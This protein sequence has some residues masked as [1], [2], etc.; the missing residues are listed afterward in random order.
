MANIRTEE[1]NGY[2]IRFIEHKG[3][4][5]AVLK[6]IC[7]ALKLKTFDVSRRLDASMKTTLR[8]DA[9]GMVSN[10]VRSRARK[11]QDMLVVN[12]EGLYECVFKSRVASAERF[13]RWTYKT[14]KK[15]RT[16]VGLKGYEAMRMLDEDTQDMIDHMLDSLYYD[17]E[18]GLLMESVTVAGGD[19]E[20]VPFE[21]QSLVE[22]L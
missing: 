8:I 13:R 20:Q 15:L 7:D 6:D 3:E 9:S 17:E 11:T 4:W 5:W 18:T 16:H 22:C 21:D 1:W 10:D 2:T 12:E 14:L 19:V